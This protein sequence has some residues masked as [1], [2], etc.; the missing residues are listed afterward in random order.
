MNRVELKVLGVTYNQIQTG[1]YALVLAQKGG[2]YRIPVVI[3]IA[4]AQSI[5]VRLEHIT[6]QRP[7][8]HDLFVSFAHAYGVKISEVFI[9]KFENGVFYSEIK[10]VGDDDREIIL[11]SR[12]SDA[13]ALAMRADVPIYTTEEILHETGF[14]PDDLEVK[15]NDNIE[16]EAETMDIKELPTDRLYKLMERCVELEDYEIAAE[17]KKIIT[18][19]EEN[20]GL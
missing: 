18:E 5:A 17:I 7:M 1:A 16:A 15:F 13:I 3:G 12:T 11:D 14:I 9:S 10:F 19:S 6:T 2:V 8:V 4:E 20:R